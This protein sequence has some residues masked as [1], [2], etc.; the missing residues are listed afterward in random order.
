MAAGRKISASAG[1]LT[2]V[3]QLIV[4]FISLSPIQ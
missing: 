4:A 2:L 1:N 3:I